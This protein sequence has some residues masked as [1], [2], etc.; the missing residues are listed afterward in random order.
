[1]RRREA[2][3]GAARLDHGQA[4]VELALGLPLLCLMLLAVVQVAVVARHQLAVDAAARDAARA[5]SVAADPSSAAT[6]A[7]RRAVALHPIDV[8]TSARADAITVTVR[9]VERTTVPMVGVLLPDV[10][11]RSSATM[12]V[13]PP[14]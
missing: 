11:L 3:P 10:V 2:Q 9:Y 4:V 7:A 8:A 13:E 5:A 1:M 6:A 14:P 12:L